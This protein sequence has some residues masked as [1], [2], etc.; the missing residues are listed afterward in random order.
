MYK[1]KITVALAAALCL[2][3]V[4]GCSDKDSSS[5]A[6]SSSA[7][8]ASSLADET[9]SAAETTTTAEPTAE[10]VSGTDSSEPEVI[11]VNTPSQEFTVFDDYQTWAADIGYPKG[12]MTAEGTDGVNQDYFHTPDSQPGYTS[13]KIVIGDSRCCQLGI[14]EQRAESEDFAAFAVWGGHFND[15]ARPSIMSDELMADFEKCFHAQA[16]ACGECTVYFFATVNDYDFQS[17]DNEKNIKDTVAAAEKIASMTYETNGKTVSPKLVIIGFEGGRTDDD[18]FG[19]PQE[20]FNR[21]VT[22]YNEKLGEAVSASGKL[23]GTEFTTVPAITA[24]NTTFNADGL[25]Y[26]DS[27]LAD[28][29]IYLV[30]N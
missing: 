2:T 21:Y 12:I 17:N 3:A 8:A 16:D 15:D 23:K 30:S 26:S 25:H 1:R 7:A 6:E 27:A 22:D 9:S 24:G 13:G 4:C 10:P 19:I 5:K 11:A 28:I 18:I 14:F 20:E 29:I